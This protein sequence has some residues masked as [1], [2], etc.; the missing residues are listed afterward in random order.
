MITQVS[1]KFNKLY[2]YDSKLIWI[3][4]SFNRIGIDPLPRYFLRPTKL[5]EILNYS[6]NPSSKNFGYK[7][8]ALT[9]LY[10]KNIEMID[11]TQVQ[12]QFD[13]ISMT[14][15][16][17]WT[18]LDSYEAWVRTTFN[19]NY[20][21]NLESKFNQAGLPTKVASTVDPQIP[22]EHY[23]VT[24]NDWAIREF[25]TSKIIQ[26]ANYDKVQVM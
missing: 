11:K 14:S 6:R 17:W 19:A 22:I 2:V 25:S 4:N 13:W 21:A 20:A 3:P 5:K 7:K 10:V 15:P 12:V 1:R 16:Y 18:D 9:G 23:Y 24:I 8:D 26:F